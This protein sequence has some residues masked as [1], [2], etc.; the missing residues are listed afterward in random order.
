MA[1]EYSPLVERQLLTLPLEYLIDLVKRGGE[2]DDDAVLRGLSWAQQIAYKAVEATDRDT[3]LVTIG[4]MEEAGASGALRG[5][6]PV[7]TEALASL[8]KVMHA[9]VQGI[10]SPDDH[11]LSI[12]LKA[13]E[14]IVRT[15]IAL[16]GVDHATASFQTEA[17]IRPLLGNLSPDGLS[18][19]LR[20]VI[21]KV[22]EGDVDK[23]G[24]Y[25]RLMRQHHRFYR[26][27]GE[28]A[29]SADSDAVFPISR[30]VSE[31]FRQL[32][33][34]L[35]IP[36][37]LSVREGLIKEGLWLK[38]VWVFMAARS[39][40]IRE[41]AAHE[42]VSGLL[43]AGMTF[44]LAEA[45]MAANE[46]AEAVLSVAK[47]VSE[48]GEPSREDNAIATALGVV[49]LLV[50]IH[51]KGLLAQEAEGRNALSTF[52]KSQGV[53]DSVP[54]GRRADWSGFIEDG[55]FERSSVSMLTEPWRILYAEATRGT[56][57]RPYVAVLLRDLFG[58]GEAET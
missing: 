20:R 42:F 45:G 17:Y 7:S 44:A 25:L 40:V 57:I 37:W 32:H 3:F 14:R 15:L 58:R 16:R 12:C 50:V 5:S 48:R 35:P 13:A 36:A 30:D 29:A 39:V 56:D 9:I 55:L 11:D 51:T 1:A 54:I 6:G 21:G 33:G 19:L 49:P 27:L 43:Y 53:R 38:A 8:G 31:S 18:A 23:V 41:H 22:Q 47:S 34:L 26:T 4:G 2:A 52:L 10:A 28:F 46:C 24:L